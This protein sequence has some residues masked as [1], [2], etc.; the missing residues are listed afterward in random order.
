VEKQA[1]RPFFIERKEENSILKVLPSGWS[2]CLATLMGGSYS[3]LYRE[4]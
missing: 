4:V 3:V 1:K 2:H